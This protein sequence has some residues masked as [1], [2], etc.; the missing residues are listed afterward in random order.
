MI[1]TLALT[2]TVS[3]ALL[4]AAGSHV[5]NSAKSAI[6]RSASQ[7]PTAVAE[8]EYDYTPIGIEGAQ[9]AVPVEI[10]NKGVVSG[11]YVDTD[12]GYHSFVWLNGTV[13]TV[14]FP[15][16]PIT[17]VSAL[18]E[19]GQLFGNWGTETEQHAG[20]YDLRTGKWT[21]LPDV[22]GYPVNIGSRMA[23]NGRATGW[24]C[25]GAFSAP[26]RCIGWIW[27]KKDYQFVT[28]PAAVTAPNGINNSGNIVGFFTESFQVPPRG[29]HG[30]GPAVR[31]L[32]VNSP[33]GPGQ[34]IA[35]DINNNGDILALANVDPA[36]LWAPVVINGE[37]YTILPKY[38]GKFQ[39]VYDGMNERGD[40]VGFWLDGPND[41]PLAFVATR[42]KGG[43]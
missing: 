6:A 30:D 24:A 22:P 19:S 13:I 8:A 12:G 14:D 23:D 7:S 1:R 41:F 2:L 36:L 29:F 34:L 26:E 10:T 42:T 27:D 39:T 37:K 20:S 28:M 3:A 9:F 15:G 5:Q 38:P 43:K 32:T 40:L 21:P 31:E 17:S 16:A 35:H 4:N 18:T 25:T 11:Y 33:Y